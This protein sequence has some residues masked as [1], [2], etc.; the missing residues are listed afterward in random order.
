MP[1]ISRIEV[2]QVDLTPKV[3]RSDAIQAFTKQETPIIRIW[4][5]DGADGTGYSYTIGT[6]G[7]AVMALLRDHM[8]PWLL[9]RD[10]AMVE[11]IWKGLF[12]HTHANAV[13]A[14]VSLALATIDI[15]LWDLRC[16]RAGCPLHVMAGGAQS[17]VPIYNTEGGWLNF[18]PQELVEH[19]I[20]AREAGFRGF[21][22]KVGRPHVSEDV[23]RLAAVRRE[24]GPEFEV[25]VDANQCFTVSEA[26]RRAKHYEDFDLAWF[27][28][29]LPAED[30][31]GH[32]R[33][34]QSTSLPIAIGESLYHPSHFR[35]YLQRGACSIVQV[36]VAR[37][38]GITPWL[39]TAHLA[40]AFNMQVCP[41]YLMEIHVALCA[42]VPNSAWVEYIP[43]L[44]LVT[45]SRIGFTDGY[46]VPSNNAGTG[47]EWDWKMIERMRV[48]HT[49]LT[50]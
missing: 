41:H 6:G 22:V 35:E 8:A 7:S 40:E 44:D 4:T 24:L 11:E 21:K 37:V 1:K 50:I 45:E 15:A 12:F 5:D 26:I 39:K 38:G 30:L 23:A 3:V 25:M 19:A 49:V 42:A 33:L 34:S 36:D 17:R 9:G 27:E 31:D 13:G 47:I 46:A 32:V 10:P 18:T 48:G 2:L 16:K 29:P 28:E 20:E 14:T 43:Q